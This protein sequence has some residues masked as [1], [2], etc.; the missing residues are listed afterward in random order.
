MNLWPHQQR[1]ID[2][3]RALLREG[4][5]APLIVLPTGAGKTRTA[6]AMIQGA[7][8]KGHHAL[9][10][11]HRIELVQQAA[12]AIRA[13][14]VPCG[15]ITPQHRASWEPV[16]VASI[17]TLIA[18]EQR[19]PA[20]LLIADEAHHL[21]A[22]S[23]LTVRE[24]YRSAYV[25]GLTATPCR[26]DGVGLGNAFDSI[27]GCVQ[28]AE[29][30]A[31][32]QLV[33]CRVLGPATSTDAAAEHVVDAYRQHAD[34]RRAIVFCSSV[35]AAEEEASKLTMAGIPA[36]NVDGRMGADKRA[37]AI[38]LFRSGHLRALTNMHVLTEGFDVRS[39]GAIILAR[40]FGSESAYIQATGRGMRADE[41]KSDCVVVDLF[42]SSHALG[43]L[44]DSDRIYSL[45][46]KGVRSGDAVESITQ[47]R[48]CGRVF[49]AAV[50]RD[51]KCPAC[52]WV[53]PGRVDPAVARA[54]I[55]ELQA[56]QVASASGQVKVDF[57]RAQL[58]RCS[59]T[60]T[61]AGVPMKPGAALIAFKARF[62]HWP[63]EAMRQQAGWPTG[64]RRTGT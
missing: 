25:I 53:R 61:K 47:C 26:S 3:T 64:F 56:R 46:G 49:R 20:D 30:I 39:T 21:V 63:N 54:R 7:F 14:G 38:E 40:K 42:G 44:P 8:A 4:K 43:I 33:K 10:I 57:L 1:T 29:L 50:F 2:Q 55:V 36:R 58:V 52:G 31:S 51:S 62:H 35:K 15:I 13:C 17:Q 11:V 12:D 41:G 59:Q 19:P 48:C 9:W 27:V 5:R 16:Q 18:R 37:E 23:Y 6:C 24:H 32:G 45:E 22:E 28:P 34:G 60:M